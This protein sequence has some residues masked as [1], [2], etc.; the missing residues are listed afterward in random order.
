MVDMTYFKEHIHEELGDAVHYAEKALS[1]RS[2]KPKWAKNFMEMSD[3]EVKHATLLFSMFE[4]SCNKVPE[5][6]SSELIKATKVDRDTM[7]KSVSDDFATAMTKLR[8]IKDMFY[9]R[10]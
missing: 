5:E 9:E 3:M 4:G 10:I 2:E 1:L 7:C 8:T 6:D